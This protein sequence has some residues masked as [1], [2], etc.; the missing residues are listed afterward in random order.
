MGAP[1]LPAFY[2]LRWDLENFLLRL[3]LNLLISASG[4]AGITAVS[5]STLL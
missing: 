1:P 4:V 5:H 2:K 3:A